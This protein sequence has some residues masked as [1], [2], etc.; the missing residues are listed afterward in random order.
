MRILGRESITL[1]VVSL[2]LL[3][4]VLA[5]NAVADNPLRQDID[6]I[7]AEV[8][9]KCV[10]WRRDIHQHPE[11]ANR[12]FRTAKLV[13][14]HLRELGMEV[15]TEVA[16]TG[17][18]GILRGR[19]ATPVVALRADMDALPVTEAVDVPFASKVTTEYGGKEVG[20]MHAC[21]HDCHT[22][23]LMAV[24]EVLS[25][26][27]GRLPGTVKFIFQPA[28]EGGPKGEEWG[29]SL[30]IREGVLEAPKPDVIFGLHVGV[31]PAPVGTIMYRPGGIMASVDRLEIVI[32][33][34]QTHGALPWMGWI[35]SWRRLRSSWD[36]K[37]R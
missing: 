30:M 27:K 24:A 14:A 15:K 23:I 9:D 16:H 11:L 19:K 5:S 13:A 20:V 28:E 29:A 12:E 36:C 8:E 21:G 32:R 3:I 35:R 37:R 31:W 22:A 17:V 18:V 1:S 26:I 4:A 6:R 25:K 34:I 10:S 2:F 33:G 7:S